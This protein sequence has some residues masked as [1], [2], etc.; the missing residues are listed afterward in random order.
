M[1][2]ALATLISLLFF[3]SI[4]HC[5]QGLCSCLLLPGT[6]LRHLLVLSPHLCL[7]CSRVAS[8]KRPTAPVPA[9]SSTTS[10][11]LSFCSLH[12]TQQARSPRPAA[13]LS[14][15]HLMSF[16]PCLRDTPCFWLIMTVSHLLGPSYVLPGLVM[17]STD[18]PTWSTS[19]CFLWGKLSCFHLPDTFPG[20][21]PVV[22]QCRWAT[23]PWGCQ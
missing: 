21:S 20:P 4:N 7:W 18:E 23:L 2:E 10:V 9:A 1:L 5:L 19:H 12:L 3:R 15:P 17:P 8:L 16:A 13:M 14:H 22:L 6:V 11:S